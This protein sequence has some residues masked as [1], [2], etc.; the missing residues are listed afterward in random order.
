MHDFAVNTGLMLDRFIAT[1]VDMS[2]SSMDLLEKVNKI[3]DAM[4]QVMKALKDIDEIAS[5][6]NLLA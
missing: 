4:P 1:T 3:Y 6:T 5:Q 2:A